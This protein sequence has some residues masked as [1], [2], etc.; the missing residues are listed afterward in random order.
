MKYCVTITEHL[1][2]N[3]TVDANSEKEAKEEV[4]KRW[5]GSEVVLTADD[6]TDVEFA[7]SHE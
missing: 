2:R 1:T 5:A 4:V 6:F 3:V 7:I